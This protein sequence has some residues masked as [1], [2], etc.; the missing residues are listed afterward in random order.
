MSNVILA[1]VCAGVAYVGYRN[2]INAIKAKENDMSQSIIDGI[3][4][5]LTKALNEIVGKFNQAPEA[6]QEQL[7]DAGLDFSAL[8]AI[9]QQLD[10]LV[11]DTEVT[12]EAVAVDE[13]VE[14]D[15]DAEVDPFAGLPSHGEFIAAEEAAEVDEVDGDV[16]DD[17][18]EVEDEDVEVEDEDIEVEDEDIEVEVEDEDSV[19]E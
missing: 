18:T 8:A 13:A 7:V 9:A 11:P 2:I 4:A 16:F 17:L 5:Q 12:D 10:D 6:V 1:V 19:E 3:V 15:E 14:V